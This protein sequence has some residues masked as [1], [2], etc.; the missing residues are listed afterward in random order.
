MLEMSHFIGTNLDN[1]NVIFMGKGSINII[2]QTFKGTF[3]S[4][5]MIFVIDF[6]EIVVA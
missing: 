6:T 5:S 4:A 2:M 1:V 3:N